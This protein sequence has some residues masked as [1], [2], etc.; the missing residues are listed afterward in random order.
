MSERNDLRIADGLKAGALAVAIVFG[1]MCIYGLIGNASRIRDNHEK[2]RVVS[3]ELASL[4]K[5]IQ[6]VPQIGA[7][8]RLARDLDVCHQ[9][10]DDYW[11]ALDAVAKTIP[12]RARAP[13][14]PHRP[15]PSKQGE[16]DGSPVPREPGGL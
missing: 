10:L 9:R 5:Q 8:E 11:K 6:A 12:G 4:K 7:I 3:S 1:C 13:Y 2:L 14:V 15:R 16:E